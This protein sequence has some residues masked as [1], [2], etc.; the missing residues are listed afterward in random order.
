[1]LGGMLPVL[2]SCWQWRFPFDDA[3]I[4]SLTDNTYS[5]LCALYWLVHSKKEGSKGLLCILYRSYIHASLF[6]SPW[7]ASYCS[8]LIT[9]SWGMSSWYNHKTSD[10]KYL[11]NICVY[12][13]IYSGIQ[14]SSW[15]SQCQT[16]SLEKHS[17]HFES[18]MSLFKLSPLNLP[19]PL[20]WTV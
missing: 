8:I 11:W 13:E 12:C 20:L 1:M 4:Y 19:A 17:S 15:E 9:T 10:T 6:R 18:I 14:V 5:V 16:S 2:R 7:I 3:F